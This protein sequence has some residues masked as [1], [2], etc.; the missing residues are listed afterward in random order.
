MQTPLH[1]EPSPLH[2]DVVYVLLAKSLV[3]IYW[4]E[5]VYGN[6]YNT[7]LI[8]QLSLDMSWA[9]VLVSL[10]WGRCEETGVYI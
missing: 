5:V 6:G 3:L 8:D 2:N 10:A 1:N 9:S 4:D 7:L